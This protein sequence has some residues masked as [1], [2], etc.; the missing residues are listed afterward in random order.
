M[1]S[2]AGDEGLELGKAGQRVRLVHT[3][4]DVEVGLAGNIDVHTA[5]Q[6]L[7]A[8]PAGGRQGS[9]P[10]FWSSSR[11]AE[12]QAVVF[13]EEAFTP[14]SVCFTIKIFLTSSGGAR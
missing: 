4:M 12:A 14:R 13:T 8:K 9:P 11:T 10:N 6:T 3:A 7:A 2:R 1:A 5:Q